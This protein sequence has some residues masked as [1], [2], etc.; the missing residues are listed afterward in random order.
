MKYM[1]V[2]LPHAESELARLYNDRKVQVIH[3]WRY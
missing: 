1:V 3:V 2:W